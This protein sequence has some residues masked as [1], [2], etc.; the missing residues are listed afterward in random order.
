MPRRFS[1]L[2]KYA[3]TGPCGQERVARSSHLDA[4]ALRQAALHLRSHALPKSRIQR[5]TPSDKRGGCK[6]SANRAVVLLKDGAEDLAKPSLVHANHVRLEENFGYPDL[7]RV[8][9]ELVLLA[10]N[11]EAIVGRQCTWRGQRCIVFDQELVDLLQTS[12]LVLYLDVGVIFLG[13]NE[14]A[15]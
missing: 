4:G 12:L 14:N 8:Q 5:R 7:L 13:L 2:R 9:V 1:G 11:P 10:H 15:R 3:G 6:H